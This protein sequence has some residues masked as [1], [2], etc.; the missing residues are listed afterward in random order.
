M[1][2]TVS[3]TDPVPLFV[4]CYVEH[5]PKGVAPQIGFNKLDDEKVDIQGINHEWHLYLFIGDLFNMMQPTGDSKIT[6]T[7]HF[8]VNPKYKISDKLAISGNFVVDGETMGSN[9]YTMVS[10]KA[11]GKEKWVTKK[12]ISGDTI[13]PVPFSFDIENG[14]TEMTMTFKCNA[15][16]SGLGIGIIFDDIN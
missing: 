14:N 4:N 11:D 6:A 13:K 9:A 8:I 15:L 16:D 12:K 2:V 7:I 10:I 3:P 1:K 5:E